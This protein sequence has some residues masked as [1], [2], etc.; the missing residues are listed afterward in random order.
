LSNDCGNTGSASVTF[1]ATDECGLT[2]T[3]TAT[4]TVEDTTD[5]TLTVPAALTL[6]CN[7]ELNEQII[8]NWLNQAT[9][10]D[11]CGTATITNSG[12]GVIAEACG[13]TG[14]YTVTF[15]ATDACDRAV[16]ET[17]TVTIVDQT[18]PTITTPASDLILECTMDG[19]YTSAIDAW[20]ATNGDGATA[21]DGCSEPLVWTFEA[22]RN[23]HRRNGTDSY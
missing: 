11:N 19:D 18:S 9:G 10:A 16:T 23:Y 15:T 5:P 6:E 17:S 2:S 20:T 14:V 13:M 1:T 8:T 7:G 3:T 4:F 21:T 12:L 22:E